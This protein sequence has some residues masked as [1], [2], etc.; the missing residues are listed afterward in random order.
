V[1]KLQ[2]LVVALA[3]ALLAATP[4]SAAS[5]SC[6]PG[7]RIFKTVPGAQLL[8]IGFVPGTSQAWAVGTDSSGS[9][10]LTMRFDGRRWSQV[11]MPM[12]AG[13]VRLLSVFAR[14]TSD[15]WAVG[16]YV[17]EHEGIGRTLA[18]H[19]N[20]NKWSIVPTPNPP[21]LAGQDRAMLWDVVALGR[22]DVWAVGSVFVEGAT[23]STST[24]AMRWNG[25]NWTIVPTADLGDSSGQLLSVA[26]VPGFE[27]LWAV[28]SG[29]GALIERY[30]NG[31]WAQIA[32]PGAAGLHDVTALAWNDA[33]AV[34]GSL[35]ADGSALIL[36][37]SGSKWRV[38]LSP[39]SPVGGTAVLAAVSAV[40]AADVW[41]VGY[42]G[43]AGS[44]ATY[45]PLMEH[46]DGS[47]WSI[48]ASPIADMAGQ[49]T[50]VTVRRSGWGWSVGHAGDG[51][52]V[53]LRHCP[54]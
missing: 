2:L 8:S 6:T 37:R 51:D 14:S 44:A 39:P 5:A 21:V 7:W 48:V 16:Y 30:R 52:A 31:S 19:W 4:P 38:V 12:P 18:M 22:H 41:A 47:K 43:R 11:P 23:P 20:G 3:V 33:W 24:L 35:L 42:M 34:G 54:S 53:I 28:G 13:Q 9:H 27:T 10:P 46:W 25:T 15:A 50:D 26:R 45:R 29:E 49:L 17:R 36:H 32:A 40:S 1:R